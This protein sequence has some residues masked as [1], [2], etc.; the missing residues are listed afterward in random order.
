MSNK[1]QP[2]QYILLLVL[3]CIL[4]SSCNQTS[5][6]KHILIIQSYEAGLPVYK[7]M[8]KIFAEQLQ[9]RKIHAEVRSIYLD[10]TKKSEKQQ[11]LTLYKGLN[12]LSSWNPDIILTCNDPAL[13]ALLTCDHP[14]VKTTPIVFTGANYPNEVFIRK[15]PNMTGF[16]NKPDYR[17]NIQLIEQLI[18]NCIIV[19]VTDDP[20][21]D[22]I[23]LTDMDQQIKD[24]CRT[25]NI[26]STE[27]IRL[28]GK[29]G[30]SIPKEKKIIP[31][32]MYISTINGKSTR[33]LIRGLGENY[34][35][36]AY[37]AIKRDYLTLSLG[38]FSS[39]P[40]F[41]VINEM[42]GYN[43]GVVGGYVTTMEEQTIL[44]ANRIADIL[45]GAPTDNFPKIIEADKKYV[46]DYKILDQWD[47]S[48]SKLPAESKIINIPFYIRYQS[49]IICIAFLLG[50]TLIIVIVYQRI[51]YKRE[52]AHKKEVQENLK[53]EKE[54]LSFALESG[55]IFTFRYKNGIFYF[56][57]EFYH[58]LD[59]PEEPISAE[60]FSNAIHVSEQTDF[61]QNRYKL[62]HGF[63]SRQ[64]TRRRYD[65]NGKGYQWWEFRYAQNTNINTENNDYSV[66]V[67][68]L[69]LNIQQIKETEINLKKALKKAEESD[70][71]KSAFLANMSHEIRTPLNA[72]VG[73][74]QLL[75]S[76]MDLE[77]EERNE[78]ISL[79]NTNNALL[80]KLINDIL[81]LS[82]IE[83]GQISF[84]YADCN[85]SQ[86]IED[87][88]NTHRLLMPQGVE[89]IKDIPEI[90]AIIYTDCFRLTQVITNFINNA[91]KFTT[92][93]YIKV[94][95][96]YSEDNRHILISVEDTGKGIPE[97]KIKLVF[98]RFQKLD[99]FAKGTGLGL[100][101]S[102]SIIKT[103]KGTIHLDSEEGKGSKFTISLPYTPQ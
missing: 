60:R 70:K 21:A 28:S 59:L 56:D 20:Y 31:D 4:N 88:F 44:G 95:Y 66:E 64:I 85:L 94:K 78:F 81:D 55:N 101:I 100:A 72:I 68:G 43:Y 33:S 41:S 84:T 65:F 22:N 80:L 87:I 9:K 75:S 12:A 17:T 11:K 39:F 98:E 30:I 89:L 62:D 15:S 47:I 5:P 1:I 63:P 34:Y 10:C 6:Q 67:N 38:R 45:F 90:P 27:R 93:G 51:L 76:D 53:R 25:N 82:R 3:F 49:Y 77:L 26:F 14:S 73:F 35:N 57:K 42:I 97:D 2:A 19:R 71:M 54:F 13:S 50:I 46:F 69:C 29:R 8:K 91:T 79:I 61:Q 92:H 32:A 23:L 102:L 37:L 16:R 99:E 103:F 18:G 96:E 48:L 36:K 40:G 58:Y 74:S 52:S 24:I 83:S 86:L 7:E